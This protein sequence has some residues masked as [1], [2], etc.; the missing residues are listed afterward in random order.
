MR[1]TPLL[2]NVQRNNEGQIFMIGGDKDRYSL[3]YDTQL[4]EWQWLP[5]LP[6]GHNISCNVCLNYND[7]AIFTFML[8][9]KFTMKAACM[10]L[11]KLQ[12]EKEKH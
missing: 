9:G 10:P 1:P 6:K 4:N 12:S 2:V 11:H 5:L 3:M 7:K 8:D